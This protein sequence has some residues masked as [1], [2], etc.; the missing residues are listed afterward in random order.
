M[1]RITPLVVMFMLVGLTYGAALAADQPIVSDEATAVDS[2][3]V[4]VPSTQTIVSYF[5]GDQRCATCLKLEAYS[6]E[7]IEQAFAD[8]LAAGTLVWRMVNYDQDENKHYIDDYRL[9]TKALILSRVVDGKEVAWKNLD[10]IWTLVGD[11]AKFVDYVQKETAAFMA[12]PEG[13]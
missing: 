10:Q 6:H 8:S 4:A 12:A 3:Q 13:E 1:T 9:Y 7:A 5:H 2:G 11:E